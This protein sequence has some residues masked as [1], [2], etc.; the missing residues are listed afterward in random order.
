MNFKTLLLF[1]QASAPSPPP[2]FHPLEIFQASDYFPVTTDSQE[3]GFRKDPV[4][5]HEQPI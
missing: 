2:A 5:E 4:D 3:D 1:V